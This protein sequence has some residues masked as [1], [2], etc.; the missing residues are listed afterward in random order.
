M[1]PTITIITTTTTYY[2]AHNARQH[3]TTQHN[4]KQT[5]TYTHTHTHTHRRIVLYK[6]AAHTLTGM[7]QL[8]LKSTLGTAS[9]QTRGV[10]VLFKVFNHGNYFGTKCTR[11]SRCWQL[12]LAKPKWHIFKQMPASDWLVCFK[13]KKLNEMTYFQIRCRHLIGCALS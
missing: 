3:N 12:R 6:F 11:K 9:P 13:T 1:P 8:D 7:C 4:T 10:P 2:T 5:H